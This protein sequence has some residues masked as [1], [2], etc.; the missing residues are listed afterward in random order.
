MERSPREALE[1]L[2]SSRLVDAEGRELHV[3]LSPPEESLAS[4][5]AASR[6]PWPPKVA[7]LIRFASGFRVSTKEVSF[8]EEVFHGVFDGFPAGVGILGD[9]AG[10]F[11]SVDVDPVTGDWGPVY[12]LCH[13]PAVIVLQSRSIVEFIDDVRAQFTPGTVERPFDRTW[14]RAM[15][16]YNDASENLPTAA[17]FAQRC[18]GLTPPD[19][20]GLAEG[21]IADLRDA[22]PGDG[23]AWDRFGA[24]TR[25][26]RM[27]R[28]PIFLLTPLRA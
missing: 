7:D 16:V 22:S 6:R 20:E 4:G 24:D 17:E 12:F 19:V 25:I 8:V 9:G 11:W 23:F 3:H 5:R 10:N 18:P 13:D 28:H 1:Q 15:E 14:R 21:R 27:G 2:R 26:T